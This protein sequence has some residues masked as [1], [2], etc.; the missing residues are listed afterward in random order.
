[1][2]ALFSAVSIGSTLLDD[3]LSGKEKTKS[4]AAD[5]GGLGGMLAGGAAGAKLGAFVGTFAGPIG[6]AIGGA[7]GGLVGSGLGYF[8]GS[9]IGETIGSWFT[10]DDAESIKQEMAFGSSNGVS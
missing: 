5:A 8:G 4:V 1:M 3:D 7:L 2:A 9:E 6:T 10:S